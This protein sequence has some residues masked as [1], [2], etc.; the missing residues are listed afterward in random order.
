MTGRALAAAAIATLL[1]LAACGGD[2][3]GPAATIGTPIGTKDTTPVPT[4]GASTD[5][6]DGTAPDPV[7][8]TLD[9]ELT[10]FASGSFDATIDPGDRYEIDTTELAN[11][12]GSAPPCDN[13][14][15]DFSWQVTDPYP[16]DGVA[17]S[18]LYTGQSDE[19]EVA[20]TPAGE[21]GVGCGPVA[22]ANNGAGAVTIAVK[23]IIGGIGG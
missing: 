13:F 11:E 16:P 14:L 7:D 23:Y 4:A 18:W 17:I 3:D 8:P 10:E 2:D 20:N 12:T 19:F 21:Q 6:G 22:I 1:L 15:F 5:T 9:E